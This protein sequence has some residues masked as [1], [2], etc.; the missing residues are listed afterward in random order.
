MTSVT[1]KHSK[2]RLEQRGEALFD[3]S[4]AAQVGEKD[5]NWIVA[6][7]VDSGDFEVHEDLL[8]AVERLQKRRENAQIW[9]R[10]VGSR[11][12]MTFGA[13]RETGGP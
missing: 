5:A 7:D 3:A 6:I 12:V 11:S 2:E 4:I 13:H 9:I 10:R 8:E 1:R